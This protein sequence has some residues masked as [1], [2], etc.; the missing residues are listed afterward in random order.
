MGVSA[1]GV[2]CS[3]P[4]PARTRDALTTGVVIPLRDALVERDLVTAHDRDPDEVLTVPSATI[5]A[6][7]EREGSYSVPPRVDSEYEC[8]WRESNPLPFD[9][10]PGWLLSRR[11]PV[12]V[13]RYCLNSS[14]V[15][16]LAVGV[17]WWP[18]HA[19]T[20]PVAVCDGVCDHARGRHPSR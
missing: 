12:A 7:G 6:S 20:A 18:T 3:S 14:A 13:D 5:Q 1:P 17:R 11:W 19:S 2:P 15:V 16:S 9:P 10:E 8:A 4:P